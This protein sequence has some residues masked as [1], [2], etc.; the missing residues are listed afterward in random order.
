M[1]RGLFILP[2]ILSLAL[3]SGGAAMAQSGERGNSG[4]GHK[5]REQVEQSRGDGH[6]GKGDKDKGHKGKD[7]DDNARSDDRRDDRYR[8]EQRHSDGDRRGDRDD[9]GGKPKHFDDRHRAYA[10]DYYANEFRRGHC[11]PGL[12]KKHNGCMPPGQAK[13]WQIGRPLPR[14]VIYYEVPRPILIQLPAPPP[15]HR[16]VPVAGEI[17]LIAVGTGIVLDALENL[18]WEFSG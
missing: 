16:Y 1:K 2:A 11:P 15:R 12:K 13:R 8:D 4:K 5:D 3:M 10:H 9:R 14:D 18:N 17:L 6:A 7:R